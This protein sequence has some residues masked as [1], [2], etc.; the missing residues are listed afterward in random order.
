MNSWARLLVGWCI[1]T[2]IGGIRMGMAMSMDDVD[3]YRHTPQSVCRRLIEDHARLS[4]LC[5]GKDYA[6]PFRYKARL[7]R[8]FQ[9]H[10][11]AVKELFPDDSWQEMIVPAE[12]DHDYRGGEHQLKADI[13]QGVIIFAKKWQLPEE[14]R[15]IL[16]ECLKG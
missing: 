1:F 16:L 2:V 15:K 9:D 6:I 5:D 14:Y 12:W 10:E 4:C 7:I 11:P 13:S 3:A 8:Y